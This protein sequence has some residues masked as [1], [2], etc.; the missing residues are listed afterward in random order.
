[1]LE[2][3]EWGD[4]FLSE[5]E[6]HRTKE[7]QSPSSSCDGRCPRTATSADYTFGA[8]YSP[9]ASSRS[10]VLT[11]SNRFTIT[12]TTLGKRRTEARTCG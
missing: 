6:A 7:P 9:D 2:Q 10:S 4:V 8:P 12:I 11:Q 1:M 3:V 5:E